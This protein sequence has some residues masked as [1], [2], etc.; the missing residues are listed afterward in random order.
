MSSVGG[1]Y[2]IPVGQHR[3]ISRLCIAVRSAPASMRHWPRRCRW[4]RGPPRTRPAPSVALAAGWTLSPAS[5]LSTVR[6]ARHR[7]IP[8]PVFYPPLQPRHWRHMRL[9]VARGHLQRTPC[10][11]QSEALSGRSS[12]L[13]IALTTQGQVAVVQADT[14]TMQATLRPQRSARGCLVPA[15]QF[16]SRHNPRPVRCQMQSLRS[17]PGH[18]YVCR[19][20]ARLKCAS[21]LAELCDAKLSDTGS[22]SHA[23]CHADGWREKIESIR[24]ATDG[25][26]RAALQVGAT[27]DVRAGCAAI[28]KCTLQCQGQA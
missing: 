17:P 4:R 18:K 27:P 6:N 22:K 21:V 2:H 10:A 13:C 9:T 8:T 23:S 26:L 20:C 28:I 14:R 5:C 25:Q 12:R 7:Y 11:V 24:E 19:H 16:A 3:D 1:P 15:A